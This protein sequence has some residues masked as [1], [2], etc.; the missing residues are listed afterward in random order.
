MFPIDD[1][2]PIT[3]VSYA[4]WALILGMSGVYLFHLVQPEFD[5]VPYLLGVVP[6]LFVGLPE[7]NWFYLPT[8]L[9]VHASFLHLIGNAW[10]LWI[11]GRQVEQFFG[12]LNTVMIFLLSGIA[13]VM[14]EVLLDPGS[15][16]AII[17]AAG[18]V[19]GV[20][21]AYL[22]IRGVTGRIWSLMP[23]VR[24]SWRSR[25]LS[26]R[27][28]A[29]NQPAWVL[30]VFWVIFQIVNGAVFV[31]TINFDIFRSIEIAVLPSLVAFLVGATVAFVLRPVVLAIDAWL[32]RLEQHQA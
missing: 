28:E 16:L 15:G 22:V 17:G 29:I 6:R 27:M 19:S 4:V 14:I 10:F 7:E 31:S 5:T 18:A 25:R 30:F 12:H 20:L 21:G 24:A 26:L 11:A 9:L 13:A 8:S 3:R 32:E 23:V 2:A 1:A